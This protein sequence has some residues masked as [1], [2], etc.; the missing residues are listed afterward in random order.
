MRNKFTV[1]EREQ[2]GAKGIQV[3]WRNGTHWHSGVTVGSIRVSSADYEL[4]GV[5]HTGRNTMTVAP[6]DRIEVGPTAIRL[7]LE[8]Q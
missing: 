6:G 1:Q 4:V 3:E 2:F 8:D 7:P 5:R